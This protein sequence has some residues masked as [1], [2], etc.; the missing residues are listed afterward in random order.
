MATGKDQKNL[1]EES[2]LRKERQLIKTLENHLI[3]KQEG[4]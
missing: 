4:L 2:E 3:G 1:K